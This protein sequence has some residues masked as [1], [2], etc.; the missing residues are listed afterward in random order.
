MRTFSVARKTERCSIARSY[1]PG[2]ETVTSNRL[3]SFLPSLVQM[4]PCTEQSVVMGNTIVT[5]AFE[6][7][8]TVISHLTFLPASSL[9]TLGNVPPVTVKEW[10]CNVE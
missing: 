4:A 10:F 7:G 5:S 3:D 2:P 8:W 1:P 9:R 6:D